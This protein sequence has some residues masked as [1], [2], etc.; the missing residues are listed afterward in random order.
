M[1]PESDFHH[2]SDTDSFTGGEVSP[3]GSYAGRPGSLRWLIHNT[4]IHPIAGW[5]WFL[6][7]ERTGDRL[8]DWHHNQAEVGDLH[9]KW[10]N[11]RQ[12][13]GGLSRFPAGKQEGNDSE[14]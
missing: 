1:L 12:A 11:K 3:D 10:W 9:G 7:A 4:M 5:L 2:I 14:V 8:H 13:S 6:G